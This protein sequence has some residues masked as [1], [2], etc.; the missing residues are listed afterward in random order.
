M[1]IFTELLND[2]LSFRIRIVAL[3]INCG[4]NTPLKI[5]I[6][7]LLKK[8]LKKLKE[9]SDKLLGYSNLY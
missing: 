5:Y 1:S 7:A 2:A 8:R 3:V 4:I 6:I 9:N